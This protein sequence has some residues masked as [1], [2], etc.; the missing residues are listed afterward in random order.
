MNNK[1]II[2]NTGGG[3]ENVVVATREAAAPKA[4]EITVRLHANSLNYHDYCVVNGM[5]GPT[6]PRIPMADGAGEVIAIGSNETEFKVGDS[7]V[8]TFYPSWL[9]GEP[10]VVGFG[11]VPGD[12]VDG[13]ARQTVTTSTNAFTHAP[14]GWSHLESSTLTT[15]AVTA[16]RGLMAEGCLKAGETVLVLGSGGVSIFALQFAKMA[17][18]RVI[19]TSSSDEKLARMQA[20]GADQIINYRAHPEWSKTVLE[21][22]NGAGVDHVIEVGGPATI[23]QS[24][25]ATRAG[26]H[27][28]VIGI[29]TGLEGNVNLAAVLVKQLRLQ[30]ILVGHRNHQ[31]DMIKAINANNL[32]PIIDKT[33]ALDELVA[34][35]KY[36]ETNQHFGKICLSID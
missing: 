17:G 32:R 28:S 31:L 29:L 34:A 3:F 35:F 30:G 18:A 4:N 11:T 19:A 6:E 16:W 5:W 10:N 8:S 22:T 36:Q 33:F 14:L 23:N 13:Y 24:I 2:V 21:M 12:G 7:V 20:L 1:A 15:A 26:G 25:A 27:I 9:H